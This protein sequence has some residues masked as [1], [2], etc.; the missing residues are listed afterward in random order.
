MDI[1]QKKMELIQ[2]LSHLQ[3]ETTVNQLMAIM[4]NRKIVNANQQQ[5]QNDYLG[6]VRTVQVPGVYI[7]EEIKAEK[8]KQRKNLFD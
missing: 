4:N 3:D 1:E 8:E 5:A 7:E 6:G 2:W